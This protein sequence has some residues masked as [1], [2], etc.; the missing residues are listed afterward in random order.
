MCVCTHTHNMYMFSLSHN[1]LCDS[2][3]T[4]ATV[5]AVK[6]IFTTVKNMNMHRKYGLEAE[7]REQIF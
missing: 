1:L 5:V 7:K 6:K 4:A 3:K 2:T